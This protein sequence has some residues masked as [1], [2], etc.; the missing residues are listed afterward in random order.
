[1]KLS[2]EH[3]EIIRDRIAQS[4]ITMKTLRDDVLD[5]LCCAVEQK[6]QAGKSFDSAF[7]EAF[8]ELAPKGLDEIQRKTFYLLNSPKIIFMKKVIYSTGL[9]CAIAISL[10]WLFT[11]LRWPGGYYLF[12]AGFL[13]FLWVF[14]PMLTVDWY[15]AKVRTKGSEKIRIV[16]GTAASFIVGLS[17]VFKLFHLQ[18]ADLVLIVG[19]LTF[20]FGFLPILFFTLYQKAVKPRDVKYE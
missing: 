1:M 10:G 4:D 7:Q 2:K 5:H 14:V 19:M 6:I 20:T 13:A 8:Q 11:I 16:I 15:R 18:G 3:I 9:I 17:A 12:N